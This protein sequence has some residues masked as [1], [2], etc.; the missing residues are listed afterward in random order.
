MKKYQSSILYKCL[1]VPLLLLVVLNAEEY[2]VSNQVIVSGGVQQ[3]GNSKYNTTLTAGQ[4]FLGTQEGGNYETSLGIWSFFLKEPDAPIVEASDGKYPDRI[5]VNFYQ[6][7]NSPPVTG[8]YDISRD[9]SMFWEGLSPTTDTKQDMNVMPGVFYLYEA[10]ATND[11][12]NSDVGSDYGFV[13]PNGTITGNVSTTNSNPVSDVEIVLSP[14]QGQA[15]SFDGSDDYIGIENSDDLQITGNQTIEMWLKPASFSVRMNPINK[16][17]YC[18]GAIT[19]ETS[20]TF[21]YYFGNGSSY[22]TSTSSTAIALNTWS[23]LAVVRDF[24]NMLIKWYIGGE[25]V[26]QAEISNDFTQAATST[27]NLKIGEGY[28]RNYNGAIDEVRVWNIVRSQADIQQDKNRKLTGA[29]TGLAG[30]WS[31]DEGSGTQAFDKTVN[32]NDG[33]INGAAWLDATPDIANSVFTDENGDYK[34]EGIYYGSGQTFTVTAQKPYHEFQ[35][36]SRQVTLNGSNTSSDNIDFTD[37]AMIAVSGYVKFENSSCYASDVEILVDS[38]STSPLTTT[39]ENGEFVIDFEPNTSHRLQPSWDNHTFLPAFYD[40]SNITAPI[41]DVV[42]EDG[43]TYTLSGV[44]AGGTCEYSVGDC[45]ITISSQNTCFTF[46]DTV[47]LNYSVSGLPPMDYIISV[48]NLDDPTITFQ[49]TDISLKEGDHTL[50]F[51]YRAPIELE[52]QDLPVNGC[53]FNVVQQL[54]PDSVTLKIFERY[55]ANICPL[56]NVHCK[57][58]D[59]FSETSYEDDGVLSEDGTIKIYFTPKE[60]NILSGG[61]YPY[62]KMLEVTIWD[63]ETEDRPAAQEKFYAYV[64]GEKQSEANQFTTTVSEMPWFV[65]RVP[66]GD[67]SY[68]YFS[69]EQSHS[70]NFSMNVIDSDG[71][72][73]EETLHLGWDKTIVAGF[74]VA[75]ETKWSITLDAGHGWTG[76]KTDVDIDETNFTFTRSETYSTS[77]DELVTGDDATVFVG[78]GMNM[79]FGIATNLQ[80]DESCNVVLDTTLVAGID[81]FNSTYMYSKYYIKNVLI[82]NLQD[83]INDEGPTTVSEDE[84]E[85]WYDILE[86]D[87]IAVATARQDNTWNFGTGDQANNISFDAGAAFEFLTS[88]DS[89][90]SN[91]TQVTVENTHEVWGE[92]GFTIDAFGFSGGYTHTFY[93]ATDETNITTDTRSE[94][95]GF[96]LDDDDPGDAFTVDVLIDTIWGMPVFKTLGG[97]SSC[98]WEEN[99]LKRQTAQ[100]T[101]DSY[102]AVDVMPGEEAVFTVYAGNASET[103]DEWDYIFEVMTNSNPYGAV[104]KYA[105]MPLTDPINIESIPSG[106]VIPLQITVARGPEEYDYEGLQLRLAPA[107][108]IEVGD[109]I[110]YY[111]N[112]DFAEF[113]VHFVRP[114]SP[115]SIAQPGSGWSFNS[116]HEDTFDIILTEFDT[117]NVNLNSLVLEYTAAGEDDW[118]V[119]ETITMDTIVNNWV[120]IKWN[121][122]YLSDG[123]YE[124]RAKSECSL[125]SGYSETLS[126]II[127]R[128]APD[129]YGTPAPADGVLGSDDVIEIVF[130]ESINEYMTVEDVQLNDLV[131]GEAVAVDFSIDDNKIQIVPDILNKYIENHQLEVTLS[132]IADQYGNYVPEPIEWEFTVNRN[133]VRWSSGYHSQIKYTDHLSEFS[134][135]LYNDGGTVAVYSL[136]ELPDWLDASP[137][138]GEIPANSFVVIDF[139]VDDYVNIGQYSGSLEAE[140]GMGNEPLAVD[141]RV[142]STPP[143]WT[144]NSADYQYS[145]NMVAELIIQDELSSDEYDMVGVFINNECRGVA[146]LS[147]VDV[148]DTYLVFL[149]VYSNQFSGNEME[150]RIWDASSSS[151]FARIRENYEFVANTQYGEPLNPVSFTATSDIFQH[152]SFTAGWNWFSM[153]ITPEDLSV[154]TLLDGMETKTGDIIK[155]QEDYAQMAESIGWLG[156]LTELNN[157]ETFKINVGDSATISLIGPPADYE[158]MEIP[159]AS[160]WNWIAYLLQQNMPLNTALQCL[161]STTNDLLKD[162]QEFAMYVEGAGWIGTLSDMVPGSGYMLRSEAVDTLKYT[163]SYSKTLI[164]AKMNSKTMATVWPQDA[165]DWNVEAADFQYN[166]NITGVVVADDVEADTTVDIMAAFV[167]NECRGVVQPIYV[168]EMD[169]CLY[170]L[171]VY[172]NS[173]EGETISFQYYDATMDNLRAIRNTVMFKADSVL[174][175]PLEPMVWTTHPLGIWDNGYI[176]EEYSLRQNYPNPF[177]PVTRIGY[178]LPQDDRVEIVIYNIL[179]QEVRRLVSEEQTA[180]YRTVIWDATD[181]SGRNVSAGIYIYSMRTTSFHKTRKM[182]LLK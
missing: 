13:N 151:E 24:D 1:Q 80:I 49:A 96:V 105:G 166:M 2:S 40:F 32:E 127:D 17:Y 74:G 126:G 4:S 142:L 6:D 172:S 173:A 64:T 97:Q 124:I 57:V 157:T 114:C 101:L 91:G 54:E 182:V 28:T 129:I 139:T 60:P 48:L 53:G 140:T 12:G 98:P 152:F 82:P 92:G 30:C 143:D 178:G 122:R 18:E 33:T 175:G 16:C 118:I 34:M 160:G 169:R 62:Q 103:G 104:V 35:P 111:N 68:T 67:G 108:E 112:I 36:A 81:G 170:F 55:G 123:D 171:T 100:I 20:G 78:G 56:E 119:A 168:P 3:M 90:F 22:C 70:V 159:I 65:L 9:G 79:T 153:N 46:T 72:H 125:I 155:S 88:T 75:V 50:D 174:G 181:Q 39:D 8:D 179:G 135:Q 69:N 147:R 132:N 76:T 23:H 51:I 138:S 128:A 38:A 116:T 165:P 121:V 21:H 102:S 77:G 110:G 117:T 154:N 73:T 83:Q 130:N 115:V 162:Q 61:D 94:T 42:F 177:N 31:F 45:E 47:N 158:N 136:V 148:L 44:I 145:V 25:L 167:D 164:L 87:S 144:V 19:Q 37:I 133:P 58:V 141:L 150:F 156:T 10:V 161:N 95:V 43:R 27:D 41:A 86:K 176:P 63:N 137:T 149:T 11:Y 109:K 180:G 99:T 106:E 5:E 71:N 107:C 93:N 131:S 85:Y 89:S 14:N 66:P 113:D 7:V 29:E 163:N 84:I 146:E 52:F 120:K 26:N 59:E 134:M 15:L